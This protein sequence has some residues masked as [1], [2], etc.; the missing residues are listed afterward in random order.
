MPVLTDE[1]VRPSELPVAP[2]LGD[3]H[4]R[5]VHPES[6]EPAPNA[7]VVPRERTAQSPS[8]GD[9]PVMATMSSVIADRTLTAC[10]RTAALCY[11]RA[12]GDRSGR[13]WMMPS[14]TRKSNPHTATHVTGGLIRS[15]SPLGRPATDRHAAE[16]GPPHC[17]GAATLHCSRGGLEAI[18]DAVTT[19]SEQSI[20]RHSRLPQGDRRLHAVLP[21]TSSGAMH[22][23]AS[24]PIGPSV[25]SCFAFAQ[26]PAQ[27]AASCSAALAVIPSPSFA[28]NQLVADRTAQ[29][30]LP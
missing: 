7:P 25:P 24:L 27:G 21:H 4:R 12:H 11:R 28:E 1:G 15:P 8:K 18:R 13:A 2:E 10:V 17:A 6:S 23:C 19:A 22:Y 14:S 29:Q 16:T 20:W 30:P 26:H 5:G 3:G 9:R